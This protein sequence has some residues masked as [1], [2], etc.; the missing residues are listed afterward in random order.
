M[1]CGLVFGWSSLVFLLKQEGVYSHLCHSAGTNRTNT[2]EDA[3]PSCSAQD[4]T[5]QL[6]FT[7]A[8]SAIPFVNF[9]IGNAFD[10]YGVRKTRLMG[11]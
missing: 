3:V 1:L 4:Q 10:R 8:S 11:M 2:T 7:I 5:L 6:A 9:F